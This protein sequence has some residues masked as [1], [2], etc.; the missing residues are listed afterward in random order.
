[1][2]IHAFSTAER[3]DNCSMNLALF[4][5]AFFNQLN[6]LHYERVDH[7]SAGFV[8]VVIV[9]LKQVL[10]VMGDAAPPSL[11]VTYQF[12]GVDAIKI[13]ILNGVQYIKAWF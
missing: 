8:G 9:E 12:M 5:L 3:P 10:G 11:F 2:P 6:L 4:L 7:V 1:M 13:S